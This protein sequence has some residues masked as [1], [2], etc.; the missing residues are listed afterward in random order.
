[1]YD[2]TL[3][4]TEVMWVGPENHQI[5]LGSPSIAETP[6]G[7]LLVSHDFFGASTLNASVQVLRNADGRGGAEPGGWAYAGAAQGLQMANVFSF[8]DGRMYLLG[9][10]GIASGTTDGRNI[11]IARSADEG[12]T[13]SAPSILFPNNSTRSYHCAPTP[14]LRLPEDGRLYRAFETYAHAS[15]ALV[16]STVHAANASMD[17]L[18][19]ASWRM[20]NVVNFS[21]PAALKR[22]GPPAPGGWGWQEGNAVEA[23]A[24][25]GGGVYNIIRVDGQTART[26]NKAGV[27]HLDADTN[28]LRFKSFID[29]PSTSSKFSVR[30]APASADPRRRYYTLSNNVTAAAARSTGTVYARNTLV[31]AASDDALAWRVCGGAPVLADDTGLSEADSYRYTG[32]HYVSW[33]FRGADI[34]YVP[35][36]GY[37]GSNSFHNANRITYKVV[38]NFVERCSN[39]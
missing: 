36:T 32:F 25:A 9:I 18:D 2:S 23:P 26:H 22:W 1:M 10:S 31:L 21:V 28:V 35:R 33:I 5:Y 37:R 20:S 13:W 3:N 15:G 14:T 38:E 6:S 39:A 11:V 30:R 8:D 4:L 29:F 17:L 27:L 24:A 16:I 34:L 19:P 7:A 12:A